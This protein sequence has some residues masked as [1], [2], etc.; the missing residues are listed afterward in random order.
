MVYVAEGANDL[1]WL[2]IDNVEI[3]LPLKVNFRSQK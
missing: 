2:K 3:R 1:N